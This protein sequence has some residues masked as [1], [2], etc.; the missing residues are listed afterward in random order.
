MNLKRKFVLH[1]DALLVIGL[2]FICSLG[3]NFVQLQQV[4]SLSQSHSRLES[5]VLVH[6]LNLSS[7]QA[8]IE[9]LKKKYEA[10]GSISQ[11]KDE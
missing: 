6:E 10:E 5:K 7:Q 11:I 8:Y 4:K 3:F 2:L 9:Q 1:L